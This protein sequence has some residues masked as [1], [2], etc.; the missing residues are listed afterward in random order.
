VPG[1]HEPSVGEIYYPYLFDLLD[2]L[3]YDGWSGASIGRRQDGRRP[4]WA[5]RYGI[6]ASL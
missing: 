5:Q 2:E 1:R 4:G 6:A 3:G